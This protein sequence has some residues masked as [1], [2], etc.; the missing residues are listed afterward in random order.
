MDLRVIER[1]KEKLTSFVQSYPFDRLNAS[2][3]EVYLN[4]FY[5]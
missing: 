5:T 2:E 4:E 1:M 3:H